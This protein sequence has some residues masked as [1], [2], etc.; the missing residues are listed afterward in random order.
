MIALQSYINDQWYS[1]QDKPTQLFNP[2]TE[3]LIAVT[4]TSGID[5]KSVLEYARAQVDPLFGQ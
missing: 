1:G 2:A 4:D 5:T 3:A